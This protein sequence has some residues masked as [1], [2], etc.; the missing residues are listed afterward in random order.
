[1]S[2][3]LPEGPVAWLH[4]SALM[5]DVFPPM[6]TSHPLCQH[7][8]WACLDFTRVVV[9]SILLQGV[10]AVICAAISLPLKAFR[11][12]SFGEKMYWVQS[13]VATIH[14]IIAFYYSWRIIMVESHSFKD[15]FLLR[16]QPLESFL[17]FSM[18]YFVYDSIFTLVGSIFC[19]E[20][21][22]IS[23]LM[24]HF[25][26]ILGLAAPLTFG[27]CTW[28]AGFWLITEASTSFVNFRWMLAKAGL[29]K[30]RAYIVNGML[31]MSFFFLFRV[32][33][34]PYYWYKIYTERHAVMTLPA[35]FIA[36]IFFGGGFFT[37]INTFWFS[38]ILKGAL[39]LFAPEKFNYKIEEEEVEE[40]VTRNREVKK[41][42][43]Q[44]K[45]Q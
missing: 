11:R 5:P 40:R 30:H 13:C 2:W 21:R 42:E 33:I 10:F 43:K 20:F 18:G 15:N 9:A 14:A 12:L 28:A 1:M 36:I 39:N 37:V 6:D 35:P 8:Q 34:A 38:K 24:H 16:H 4:G 3:S 32:L 17:G 7:S 25:T 31:M 19:E 26:S 41:H 23:M 44:K 29:K 22:S 27:Q 45:R